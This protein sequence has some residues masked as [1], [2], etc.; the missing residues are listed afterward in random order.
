MPRGFSFAGYRRVPWAES[1][2]G[3]KQMAEG[4][5]QDGVRGVSGKRA[6]TAFLTAAHVQRRIMAQD[7]LTSAHLI[8]KLESCKLAPSRRR[9]GKCASHRR[10]QGSKVCF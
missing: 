8:A 10:K 7:S 1:N 3:G 9:V 6:K 5:N 2:E 4:D